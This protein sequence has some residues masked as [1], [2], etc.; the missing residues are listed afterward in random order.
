MKNISISS[1]CRHITPYYIGV[2]YK[3]PHTFPYLYKCPHTFPYLS[4]DFSWGYT[5]RQIRVTVQESSI[6]YSMQLYYE[7]MSLQ[8]KEATTYDEWVIKQLSNAGLSLHMPYRNN[9][10]WKAIWLGNIKCPF[11]VIM[12]VT[13]GYINLCILNWPAFEI[14]H[15]AI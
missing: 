5:I 2:I 7:G 15:R 1:T 3:C 11:F 12:G 9:I 10:F 6:N 13:K 14:I 8:R 4:L